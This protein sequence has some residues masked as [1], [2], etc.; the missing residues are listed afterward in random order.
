MLKYLSLKGDKRFVT[1][2]PIRLIEFQRLAF[3]WDKFG[4]NKFDLEDCD[5][6]WCEEIYQTHMGLE[7]FKSNAQAEIQAKGQGGGGRRTQ[8]EKLL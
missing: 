2:V 4:L 1:G 7:S 6:L 8:T 3:F 5:P